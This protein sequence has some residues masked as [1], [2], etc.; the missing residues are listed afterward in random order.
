MGLPPEKLLLKWMNFHLK[1]SGYKKQVTNFSSDLKVMKALHMLMICQCMNFLA[2]L[3]ILICMIFM[4]L[5]PPSKIVF[6]LFESLVQV[7][8]F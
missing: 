3:R 2:A 5:L 4:P 7:P 6:V 1:K 8:V